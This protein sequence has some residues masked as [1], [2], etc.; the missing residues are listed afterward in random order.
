MTILVPFNKLVPSKANVRRVRTDLAPLVA[1][2]KSE[3]ILQNLVVVAVD[4][5]RYEVV[6]GERRRQ[7]TAVLV[8]EGFWPKDQPI[9]CEARDPADAVAISIAE[10]VERV[11]MHPADAYWAFADLS[12]QGHDETAIAHRYGYE[13]GEVRRLLRLGALSPK[14][15]K[16]LAAD[17][18]DV[19]FAQA[20]TLT[21]DHATQEAVLK[22]AAS[23]HEARRM[24]TQQKVTTAHRLFRFVAD[25]YAAAGGTLTRDLFGRDGEGYADDAELV[26]RLVTEKLD[27]L[28]EE[29]RD[30]GWSEVV[31]A[32]SEPY[33][34][35]SWHRLSPDGEREPTE[36]EAAEV[37]EATA[38]IEARQAQIGEANPS[39][40]DRQYLAAH[41][42]VIDRIARARRVH[43]PEQ[44]AGGTLT[45]VVD[46]DGGVKRTAYTKRMPSQPKVKGDAPAERPL[47]AA[48]LAEDLSKVRTRAL[49]LEIARHP[50]LALDVLLDALL[51]LVVSDGYSP[52]HAVQ[53]RAEAFRLYGGEGVNAQ[54]VPA[55]ADE[56]ADLLS[57]MP[58]EPDARF[59]WLRGQ[60]AEA[61]ARL[62]AFATASLVNAVEGKFTDGNRLRCADR[63]A[64]AAS[65]D[66][67]AHW[68]G[69]VDFY[70]RLTKRACLAA[71]TEAQGPAAA[72]NCAKLPKADL[73]KACADRIPGTGWLPE[74][75]RLPPEPV[76]ES[77]PPDEDES[78]E[79]AEAHRELGG[80]RADELM[81]EAAE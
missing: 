14:A 42:A 66:M 70:D 73:A 76:A 21:D 54:S 38:L 60:G 71:L 58:R 79:D 33:Q 67:N 12:A 7:A 46:H 15:L 13:P 80:D 59:A 40:E 27:R 55:P 53:L 6:A 20:L 75:L 29:A 72:E 49:Q 4:N 39:P 57:V 61:K 41:Q 64:R 48:A 69:G 11:A 22:R 34:A 9:P 28:A 52:P 25:E 31:A 2:L 63:I 10:N 68:S 32:E 51:P 74:P 81:R 56:A 43:T 44:M 23:A 1:S 8:K 77:E 16:A 78:G 26:Q 62:L 30:D 5:G 45:I 24:L 17:K 36:R 47:Y 3:G 35:Y 37:A 19:A 65:L 50:D 18:I